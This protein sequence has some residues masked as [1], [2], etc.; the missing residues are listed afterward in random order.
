[1][2]LN[3]GDF[4]DRIVLQRSAQVINPTTGWPEEGFSTSA[5]VWARFRPTGG[6]E[7]RDGSAAVGEERATFSMMYRED[8]DQTD[9]IVFDG[10]VWNIQ[11]IARVGWKESLD[12]NC[13][14]SGAAP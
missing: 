1:M 10:R 8:I 5:T 13:T 3:P 12:V 7:F 6:R 11:S 14:T 2:T 4:N 9:R